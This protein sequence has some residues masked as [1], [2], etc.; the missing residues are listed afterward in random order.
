MRLR[1]K[2]LIVTLIGLVLTNGIWVIIDI[3]KEIEGNK[4]EITQTTLIMMSSI[5]DQLDELKEQNLIAEQ[6]QISHV[7]NVH[8]KCRTEIEF[9]PT[10]QW[11]IKILDKKKKLTEQGKKIN[12]YPNFMF[13][14][15]ENW[16][17]GLEWDWSISR[18][19]HFGIPIPVWYCK[20]CNEILLPK[21]NELP[22]DPLQTSKKC[23][24]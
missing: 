8:D 18:N 9:L 14:R 6:K 17:K 24:K 22:V 12:W 21:E 13:K 10:E 11:F 23:L 4:R 15:Y 7:V 16:I 2:I 19:R 5:Q 20:E 3:R 1:L